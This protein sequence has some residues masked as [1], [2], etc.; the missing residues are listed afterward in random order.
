MFSWVIFLSIVTQLVGGIRPSQPLSFSL[1]VMPQ[2]Y[3][4][5][6]HPDQPLQVGDMVSFEIY[7]SPG[8]HL[9]GQQLTLSLLEGSETV[10]GSANFEVS[11]GNRY[12]ATLQW[13]WDTKGLAPGEYTLQFL[14]K[15]LDLSWTQLV[16]LQPAPANFPYHWATA[17]AACCNIYYITGTSAARDI[18]R[19][20]PLIQTQAQQVEK[21]MGHIVTGKIDIDLLPRV[22]GQSG[23]T[24]NEIYLTY[25]DDNYTDTNFVTVLHHELVHRVDADMGGD[26]R[27]LFLVEGLAVY[28]T[29]GHYHPEALAFRSA[30]LMQVGLFIPLSNLVDDFYNW[31]HEI[32]YLE[33]GSLV[34]YMV[35]TW[36]WNAYNE[37]YRD[38]HISSGMDDADVIDKALQVHFGISLRT[39]DDRF[40]VYLRA[41]PISPDLEND[42]LM[43]V[44]LFDKIRSFQQER[45]PSAY[46]QEVWLP[47]AAEM[48]KRGIVGDYLPRYANQQDQVIESMLI[49]AG[50]DWEKG[51]YSAG[52]DELVQ[53]RA[54]LQPTP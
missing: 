26:Y 6:I 9:D 20:V 1:A 43:T 52:V 25:V 15:P 44:Q 11:S 14:I 16:T 48:R 36:G 31:Q 27:P 3:E 35:D 51:D 19:L 33:A 5:R 24:A 22:V 2:G 28:M 37:F 13:I 45:D 12:R 7:S 4:V 41:F 32:G 38:I 49:S 47:D 42:V 10:L 30:T 18:A 29:G 34:E 50:G 54:L 46:F 53:I 21:E 40:Q 8:A 17:E 39:L 23:F